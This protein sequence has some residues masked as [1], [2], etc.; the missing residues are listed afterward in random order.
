[1]VF[2][3]DPLLSDIK[4]FELAVKNKCFREADDEELF[5]LFSAAVEGDLHDH[6]RLAEEGGLLSNAALLDK[7]IGYSTEIGNTEIT[8][9]LLEYKNKKI[10]FNGGNKYEL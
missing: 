1:M 10:G 7:L 5:A 2:Q 3:S 4:V 6:L 8:A 9:R